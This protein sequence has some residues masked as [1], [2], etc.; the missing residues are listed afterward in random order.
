MAVPPAGTRSGTTAPRAE[1]TAIPLKTSAVARPAPGPG[2][3]RAPSP[4][5]TAHTPPILQ[6]AL[7]LAAT[8]RRALLG[9]GARVAPGGRDGDGTGV[10]EFARVPAGTAFES[11]C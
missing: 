10:R 5:A 7:I 4:A 6:E 8:G 11:E 9:T 2:T 3:S 1:A